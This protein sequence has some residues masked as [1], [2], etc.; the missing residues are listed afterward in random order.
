MNAYVFGKCSII[1]KDSFEIIS[2]NIRDKCIICRFSVTVN[3][4]K[5][6][7]KGFHESV[8]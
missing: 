2:E 6:V 8:S 4:V 3:R 1:L 7:C 5:V